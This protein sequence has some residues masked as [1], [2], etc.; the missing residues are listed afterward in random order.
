L[1]QGSAAGVRAWKTTPVARYDQCQ[2]AA[3][4]GRGQ[5]VDA[6]GVVE[7]SYRLGCTTEQ[8]LREILRMA[9]PL[10]EKDGG[11]GAV[12]FLIDAQR[13]TPERPHLLGIAAEAIPDA[14]FGAFSSFVEIG[15]KPEF[16]TRV[17]CAGP[18]STLSESVGALFSDRG[19]FEERLRA[20]SLGDA[21]YVMAGDPMGVCCL[22]ASPYR[23]R[24]Q[25]AR[26]LIAA[27]QLVA[28][29]I[30]AGFR[31]RAR[32]GSAG[33]PSSADP[34]DGTD[35]IFDPDGRLQHA[36]GLVAASA[37]HRERLR[38]AARDAVVARGAVRHQDPLQALA[39]W[40]ALV[41][42][43]WS[44]VDR[45]DRDGRRFVVARRNQPGA[46]V[47]RALSEREVQV[48]T[49]VA[50]GHP[51]KVVGYELGIAES[52]VATL[53]RRA[54]RKLDLPGRTELVDLF[55]RT[56]P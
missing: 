9:R 35:A 5:R 25:M 23:K 28:A 10:F 40:R 13:T 38:Q 32:G 11:E 45:F 54:L 48:A 24:H 14:A 18:V 56:L 15:A 26:S 33:E 6:I 31:L 51:N 16:A 7:A 20:H 52:T 17:R 21:G 27:W 19:G 44:M 29:H 46:R 49:L 53:L 37:E 34:N 42:G 1:I 22:L 41:S 36:E 4:N 12:A 39:L 30:A 43:R 8:W 2:P 55:A 50:F 3:A 47:H